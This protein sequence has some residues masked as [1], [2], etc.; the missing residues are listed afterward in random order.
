MGQIIHFIFPVDLT[1]THL[2][3]RRRLE[4]KKKPQNPQTAEK[5]GLVRR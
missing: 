4:M 5:R 3:I 1:R 2:F